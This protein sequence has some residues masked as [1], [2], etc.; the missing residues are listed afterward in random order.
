LIHGLGGK[1]KKQRL[2]KAYIRE[3]EVSFLY[4]THLVHL[5]VIYIPRTCK[6]L[7]FLILKGIELASLQDAE[8]GQSRTRKVNLSSRSWKTHTLLLQKRRK[9]H[10]TSG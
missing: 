8:M 5:L 2:L 4:H 6:D 9:L 10:K 3:R 1:K 7:F